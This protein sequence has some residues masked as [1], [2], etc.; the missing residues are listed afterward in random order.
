VGDLDHLVRVGLDDL[1]RLDK[2]VDQ[3]D[4]LLQLLAALLLVLGARLDH[5]LERLAQGGQGLLVV[6]V[7]I[8][9]HLHKHAR[10]STY[11]GGST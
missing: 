5:V 7:L 2:P 1:P 9:L 10:V 8:N 3:V 11:A 4:L 6:A